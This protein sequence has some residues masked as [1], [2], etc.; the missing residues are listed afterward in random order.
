MQMIFED[1]EATGGGSGGDGGSGGGRGGN[2]KVGS[3]ASRGAAD[4]GT[5]TREAAAIEQ[6]SLLIDVQQRMEAEYLQRLA[7]SSSQLR[8]SLQQDLDKEQQARREA[9]ARNL[10]LLDA[11][12]NQRA[13]NAELM[14]KL[15]EHE[16]RELERLR[17][18]EQV[19]SSRETELDAF[20]LQA[21]RA[22]QDAAE[23]KAAREQLERAINQY[24]KILDAIGIQRSVDK[25]AANANLTTRSPKAGGFGDDYDE[26]AQNAAQAGG[27]YGGPGGGP[28]GP[29]GYAAL[30]GP[31]GYDGAS[32]GGGGV[33]KNQA[34]CNRGGHG[35]GSGGSYGPGGG[36]PGGG[37]PTIGPDGIVRDANGQPVIGSDGLPMRSPPGGSIGPEG[38][39][40][41]RDGNPV[42]GADGQPV[43]VPAG[44]GGAGGA[45]GGRMG[46]DGRMYGPDGQPLAE[47][48]S[49]APALPPHLLQL[50]KFV[51][52][53]DEGPVAVRARFNGTVG[54]LKRQI[55]TQL[56][57]SPRLAL[58]VTASSSTIPLNDDAIISPYAEGQGAERLLLSAAPRP[59]SDFF[60][61]SASLPAFR[62]IRVR[63]LVRGVPQNF[64]VVLK[65]VSERTTAGEIQ[66]MLAKQPNLLPTVDGKPADALH[67]YF[68]PVFITPDV[69][70]GR[71]SRQVLKPTQSLG[72]AQLIDDDIVYL[73]TD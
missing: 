43:R 15:T 52:L 61:G 38:I 42:I 8:E 36:G 28:G 3:S 22:I 14:A 11:V 33:P 25:H 62:Q 10:A 73:S 67:L 18:L 58:T 48:I 55:A 54:Y 44:A 12:E 35:M 66:H 69:L 39:M 26:R 16:A 63:P 72:D 64:A 49:V 4:G 23:A 51:L 34:A 2:N 20:R 32:G 65:G 59:L 17:Q 40:R 53:T 27:P 41:D 60:P 29:G 6:Q 45:G 31:D 68:S 5:I 50:D 21:E 71:K 7:E 24:E 46:S 70:L 56:H 1:D 57:I 30:G 9:Q 37:M 13:R 19:H 47:G